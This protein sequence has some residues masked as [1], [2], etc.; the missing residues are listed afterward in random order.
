[1]SPFLLLVGCAEF[2]SARAPVVPVEGPWRYKEEG[3]VSATCGERWWEPHEALSVDDATQEGFTLHADHLRYDC[4]LSGAQFA[5]SSP[6][7]TQFGITGKVIDVVFETSGELLAADRLQ[8]SHAF[9][10]RCLGKDC[11]PAPPTP[12]FTSPC[13]W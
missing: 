13:V 9:T 12:N 4:H 10:L 8:G 5:C 2:G 7:S 6:A 3:V 1:M 11:A